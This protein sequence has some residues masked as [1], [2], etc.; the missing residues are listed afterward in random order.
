MITNVVRYPKTAGNIW[1]NFADIL[2]V[3]FANFFCLVF[4]SKIGVLFLKTKGGKEI[5]DP[6]RITIEP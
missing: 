5:M 4:I 1:V 6:G 3:K 2:C